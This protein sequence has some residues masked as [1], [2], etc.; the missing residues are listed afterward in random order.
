MARRWK[1]PDGDYCD[2]K[3]ELEIHEALRRR[4]EWFPEDHRMH[5][6]VRSKRLGWKADFV[7]GGVYV[8]YYGLADR[9]HLEGN[10]SQEM[11]ARVRRYILR[12]REK[13]RYY[14][15][16]KPTTSVEIFRDDAKSP[17]RLGGLMDDVL[18]KSRPS[19]QSTYLQQ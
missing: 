6:S 3:K 2:S 12:M 10:L 19:R 7:V 13:H 16:S 4:I 17:I 18:S 9:R 5:P 8:E 15:A 11:S 14:T 1:A